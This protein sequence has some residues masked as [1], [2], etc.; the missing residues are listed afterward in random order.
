VTLAFEFHTSSAIFFGSGARSRL[1]TLARSLGKRAFLVTGGASLARSGERARLD[2]DLA[3]NG[4]AVVSYVVT[5]EPDVAVV[6]EGAR[7]CGE[8][9]CEVVIAVGGGSVLDAAKAVA[10]LVSNG[11]SALD[12]LGDLPPGLGRGR[13]IT[14]APLPFVAVPT[15]AGSGSEVTKNAVLR[16]PEVA[17]KRSLRSDLMVPRVAIVDPDL[18]R[19]APS[20]VF[21]PAAL[22]ALTHLLEAYVSRGAGPMTDLLA[23]E[24]FR[25]SFAALSSIVQGAPS[26]H[27]DADLSLASLW[28]GM[29][30][31]NASL[32]AVHGLVAPLGGRFPVPHGCGCAAL[33]AP[34]IRANIA[35][36]RARDPSS[37]ALVR[38]GEIAR[39]VNGSSAVLDDA[40]D[41]IARLR[42]AL[43]AR[44]LAS[45]G[46]T[47]AAFA[48][49]IAGARGGSMKSNPIVLTDDELEAVLRESLVEPAFG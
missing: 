44:S 36:L 5:G 48:E 41:G 38:Y 30:L 13:S 35:A 15:T 7:L 46:V 45:Y 4:I 40:A 27:V 42:R 3:A 19:G 22:D 12:Y 11:G 32:G 29:V 47:D 25:R 2:A 43:G 1:G 8:G 21:V 17:L 18:S 16:V 33:L 28:G 20:E 37:R 14:K 24:G 6:D 10:A 31:A 23:L 49:V 34:T 9:A 39:L 26:D